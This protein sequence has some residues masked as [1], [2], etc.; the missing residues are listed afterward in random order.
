MIT[1]NKWYLYDIERSSLREV[2]PQTP[3]GTTF[4][5][6]FVY[7][8]KVLVVGV[9][10]IIARNIPS[11]EC[12]TNTSL[13]YVDFSS[14]WPGSEN[15]KSRIIY[16]STSCDAAPYGVAVAAGEGVIYVVGGNGSNNGYIFDLF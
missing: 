13:Y 15:V 4:Y 10:R 2:T 5:K 1:A 3:F 12:Y 6:A 7:G 16:R 11:E 9:S 14:G 8:T